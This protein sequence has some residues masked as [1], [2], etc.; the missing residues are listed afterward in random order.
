MKLL[1]S[2]IL[3]ALFAIPCLAI[4]GDVYCPKAPVCGHTG[5]IFA[6][7]GFH[8]DYDVDGHEPRFPSNEQ[9]EMDAGYI[10]GAG[11]GV[12][13]NFLGGGRFEFE[14]LSAKN[15]IGRIRSDIFDGRGF[16]D[17]GFRGDLNTKAVM[18]NIYKEIPVAGFTGYLGAGPR[19][20]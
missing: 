1:S 2:T 8:F 10:V 4:S 3:A 12:Y 19:V 17:Y 20:F 9:I 15:D 13:T 14:G 18:A 7:G 11:A 6:Y 5:Y 16:I